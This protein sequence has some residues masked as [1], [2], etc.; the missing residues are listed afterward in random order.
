MIL[1]GIQACVDGKGLGR[2]T[3]GDPDGGDLN[4]KAFIRFAH[5]RVFFFLMLYESRLSTLRKT[6]PGTFVQGFF[7]CR[8]GRIRTCDPLVPNQM[9]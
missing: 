5:L 7:I 3:S 9:R 8:G 4:E 1:G 2:I 6:K